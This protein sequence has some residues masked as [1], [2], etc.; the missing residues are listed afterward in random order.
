ML[1][2]LPASL[3]CGD[4]ILESFKVCGSLVDL[5]EGKRYP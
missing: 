5:N 4:V 3:L 2:F 1:I